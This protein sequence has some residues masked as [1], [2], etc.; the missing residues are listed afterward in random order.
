MKLCSCFY[1][2]SLPPCLYDKV[3][4]DTQLMCKMSVRIGSSS[5]ISIYFHSFIHLQETALSKVTVDP[6]PLLVLVLIL[7]IRWKNLF[8]MRQQS[9]IGHHAHTN[10]HTFNTHSHQGQF[11]VDNLP[12][13]AYL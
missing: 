1:G 4:Y 11:S 9:I 6:E 2:Y 8:Q 5:S 3:I 13:P 10:I 12:V 7:G